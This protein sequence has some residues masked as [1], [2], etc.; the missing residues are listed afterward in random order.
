MKK[1]SILMPVY[2]GEHYINDSVEQIINQ[3]FKDYELVIV[4]DS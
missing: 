3:T 2:N 1:R 4:N